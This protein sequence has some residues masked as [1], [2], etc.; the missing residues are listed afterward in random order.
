MAKIT[1]K[2]KEY[3]VVFNLNVMEDIQ[4]E[5]ETI[6]KWSD[7][8]MGEN[9]SAKAIKFGIMAMINEGIDIYN[10]DHE[11]KRPF[12]T[13]RQIGRLVSDVGLEMISEAMKNS[14]VDS[15]K[16]DEKNS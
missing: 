11:D 5:F 12:F 6:D 16:S 1:Y 14:V 8:F 13:M 15:T 10:E 3:D 9:P 4:D 7:L 2:D